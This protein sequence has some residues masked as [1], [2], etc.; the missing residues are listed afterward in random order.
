MPHYV[1]QTTLFEM[2]DEIP[3]NLAAHPVF[4]TYHLACKYPSAA[5]DSDAVMDNMGP[6]HMNVKWG[7]YL[8]C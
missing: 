1:G 2:V 6:P 5:K 3:R 7:W 4:I 8:E